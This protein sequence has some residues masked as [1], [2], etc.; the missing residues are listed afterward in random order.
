MDDQ[1]DKPIGLFEPI[2]E[3]VKSTAQFFCWKPSRKSQP[4]IIKDK[5]GKV[6]MTRP[7]ASRR[8]KLW[9]EF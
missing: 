1:N 5:N 8:L 7:C 2:I 4:E 3:Q 9:V 6:V